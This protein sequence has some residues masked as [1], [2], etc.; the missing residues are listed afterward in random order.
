MTS[1]VPDRDRKVI[2]RWRTFASTLRMGELDSVES[3]KVRQTM[4]ADFL[5]SKVMAWQRHRTHAH[6]A[7]LVGAAI[8]LGRES[9]VSEAA[10]FLLQDDLSASN[11]GR[12]LAKRVLRGN[13]IAGTIDE[14]PQKVESQHLHTQVR[15]FRQLLRIEPRD[16]ITWV[17]LSRIYAVL[18]LP[19]Q[20][21]RSM[22]IALQLAGDNRFVLRSASRLWIHQDDPERAHEVVARSKRTR[23]DPWL[24]A[25]EIATGDAAGRTSKFTKAAARLLSKA[26][27][28]VSHL[29]ELASAVATLELSAGR[30]KKM[31]SL[32]AKSLQSP[33]ENS[34]AQAAWASRQN[35]AVHFD[36]SYLELPNTYEARS[37]TYYQKSRWDQVIEDCKLWQFDQPFSS[38][39]AIHGS[40]VAA[41][42]LEDYQLSES[43]VEQ[44]LTSNP[45]DV[46]LLN[47]LAFAR[48]NLGD[49]NGAAAVLGRISKSQASERER[50]VLTATR[51]LLAYRTADVPRGRELYNSA[52]RRARKLQDRRLLSLAFIFYAL[53]E[54]SHVREHESAVITEALHITKRVDDPAIK[55]LRDKLERT[56]KPKTG[57]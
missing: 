52:I 5:A 29:S 47:N 46:T 2:P 43:F 48:V 14:T 28:N 57:V 42:A 3:P 16:P 27:S 33:T 49:M 26:P 17:D 36:N 24:L 54:V 9:E 22:N 1:F 55:V 53:E 38:R 15:A 7:D 20:A 19:D 12:E 39:P 21:A 31:R 4:T 40:Y 8:A 10:A 56:V 13:D 32:F 37:W 23:Y 18:G 34:V 44:G 51:G 41:I 30:I 11:W 25:A 50:I 35:H 6:A 45:T